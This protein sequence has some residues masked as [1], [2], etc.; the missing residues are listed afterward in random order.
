[1]SKDRGLIRFC[2]GAM[3]LT[4]SG[5]ALS[6]IVA[7]LFY[8]HDKPGEIPELFTNWGGVIIGFYFGTFATMMKDWLGSGTDAD[9]VAPN[10]TQATDPDAAGGRH[11]SNAGTAAPHAAGD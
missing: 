1:M 3:V 9:D 8:V 11:R 10:N 7:T 2:T 6:I 4:S 5:I